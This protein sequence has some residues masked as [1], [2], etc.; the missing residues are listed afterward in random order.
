V[1]EGGGG[2]CLTSATP[3]VEAWW[4]AEDGQIEMED[5]GP[6]PW[7]S[8]TVEDLRGDEP[9]DPLS[10]R[11][12]EMIGKALS[13]GKQALLL[14]AHRGYAFALTC[15]ECG[16]TI[17][18]RECRLTMTYRR[19]DGMLHCSLCR[20]TEK[21]RA[22]CP[23]CRGRQTASSG[24][25]TERVEEAVRAAFPA[26]GVVR[27]DGD[28]ARGASGRAL[29]SAIRSGTARIIVGPRSALKLFR[30][31]T[32]GLAGLLT[33]DSWMERP[34]FR[35]SE[36]AW[37]L[38]WEACERVGEGD[39]LIQ[40]RH[41]EHYVMNSVLHQD[42]AIFYRHEL[43]FRAELEYPPFSRLARVTVRG[44]DADQASLVLSRVSQSLETNAPQGATLYR[45][46]PTTYSSISREWRLLVK[47]DR[48]LPEW[49]GR[50]LLPLRSRRPSGSRLEIDI[51]PVELT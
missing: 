36:R 51:D 39:T 48:S 41:P 29:A 9:R 26:E 2:L 37:Q 16:L 33:P 3:S 25:G 35:A 43:K 5:G 17:R 46:A 47:G 50:A 24:W 32:L 4:Q 10:L 27:Y 12:Q 45:P 15:M 18:C 8:V 34:D 49:V 31:G 14:A 22:L 38:I 30:P 23:R 44:K 19:A 40:T 20:R 13:R 42:K 7:P 11:L 6:T 28:A 21:A 1:Y